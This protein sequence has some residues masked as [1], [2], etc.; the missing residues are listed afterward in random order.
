MSATPL[1]RRSLAL[2]QR[3]QHLVR[4]DREPEAFKLY[5]EAA[6]LHAE[7]D[8]SPA[9][10]MCW[11]DLAETYTRR[12]DGVRVSNLHAAEGLLR[13]TLRS[14]ALEHDPH[15][16]AMVRDALASCLRHLAEEP[17]YQT[18]RDALLSEAA[19]FFVEAIEIAERGGRVAWESLAQY[20]HNLGNLEAQRGRFDKAFRRMSQAENFARALDHDEWS[21]DREALLSAI[22]VHGAQDQAR[23]GLAGDRAAALQRLGGGAPHRS[24]GV[25]T[26]GSARAGPDPHRRSRSVAGAGRR[27]AA[28]RALGRSAA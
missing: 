11:Y 26:P 18:P 25:G 12:H 20:L 19:Q 24:P 21:G 23:R 10:V 28:P 17:L 16:A 2:R 6:S 9:A 22:L 8:P 14:P 13:R 1:G 4:A 5:E 7:D 15:R 27:R 3:A